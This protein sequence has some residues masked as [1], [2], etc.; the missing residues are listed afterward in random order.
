MHTIARTT[1][2]AIVAASLM[3]PTWAASMSQAAESVPGAIET[4]SASDSV[5]TDKSVSA[6]PKDIVRGLG[7]SE[8][9]TISAVVRTPEGLALETTEV[10]GRAEGKAA[11]ADAQ[12]QP[13]TVAVGLAAPVRASASDPYRKEQWALGGG[14]LDATSSWG[15]NRGEGTKVA[16]IDTG[17]FPHEDLGAVGSGLIDGGDFINPGRTALRDT[18]GHGTVVAGIIGAQSGNG[19]GIAGLAPETTIIAMKVLD[20]NGDGDTSSV[21]RA[22]L[23]AIEL[24]VDVINLSLG[25]PDPDASLETAI[26]AAVNSGI[27]VVA[28]S[29]NH[30]G[31]SEPVDYPAKYPETIA[32]GATTSSDKIAAFSNQG[33]EVDVSAPGEEILS[34]GPNNQYVNSDGTSMATP[35]VAAT[36]AMLY[37]QGASSSDEVRALLEGSALDRGAPDKDVAF[38][39]GRIQTSKALQ[40]AEK[41]TRIARPGQASVSA[42]A[43]VSGVALTWPAIAYAE[44]LTYQVQRSQLVDGEWTEWNTILPDTESTELVLTSLQPG[45]NLRFRVRALAKWQFGPYSQSS[46]TVVPYTKPGQVRKPTVAVRGTSAEAQWKTPSS[47]GFSPIKGY[48]TRLALKGK[49]P[50]KWEP[51]SSPQSSFKVKRNSRYVLQIRARNAAGPGEV[52]RKA[53]R[54]R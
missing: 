34:T 38:G 25:G 31:A 32:V 45:L 20:D 4:E 2:S 14:I 40:D 7:S 51:T 37:R 21:A 26:K 47:N 5:P 36:A 17:V 16:V 35:Y 11:V 39:V 6:P 42:R 44:R 53:F 8:K 22:I 52:V 33:P 27:T 54:V 1:M 29:G 48:E 19:I 13:E 23:K 30:N 15:Y 18:F 49:R 28:A 43:T 12:A 41:R 24:D 46:A 50:G 3:V 10:T 9:G